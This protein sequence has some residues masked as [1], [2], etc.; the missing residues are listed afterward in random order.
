VR[1][2]FRGEG[3]I[4]RLEV[5]G[6]AFLFSTGGAAIKATTLTPWQVAGGRSGVAAI[7]LALMLPAARRS[8]SW[9]TIPVALAYAATL[10]TFAIANKLTTSAAT[11]Y[12][13]STG[14]FYLLLLSPLLLGERIRRHDLAFLAALGCG[15]ALLFAGNPPA[16]ATAP[17]PALGNLLAAGSG[18]FFALTIAGLR[19]L[20]RDER[21]GEARGAGAALLGNLFAFLLTLPLALPVAQATAGDA[22]AV[23]YLG[24]FQIALAYVLLTRA[25]RAVPAFEASL[26]LLLEPTLNPLWSWLMHGE[27]PG[28]WALA[29]GAV[30][31]GATLAHSWWASTCEPV[32]PRT[33]S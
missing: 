30:I 28:G 10:L 20:A 19:W 25:L 9:R 14:P 24:T 8:I 26:L 4:P 12:L 3:A 1:H 5:L 33:G 6:A 22:V 16:Q 27:N 21:P 29:G 23:A 31:I 15:M 13:Q 18:L 32:A 7:A 11:I 2:R 17:N